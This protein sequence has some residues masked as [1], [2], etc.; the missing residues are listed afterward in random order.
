MK[1]TN[2][3]MTEKQ[4]VIR[5][6]AKSV[7]NF[8]KNLPKY[9]N[10][11]NNDIVDINDPKNFTADEYEVVKSLQKVENQIKNYSSAK[12]GSKNFKQSIQANERGGSYTTVLKT[13]AEG[14]PSRSERYR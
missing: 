13:V 4:S 12:S 9:D 2:D 1:D 10:V 8:L 7:F 11:N 6:A 5:N 14:Q 3:A